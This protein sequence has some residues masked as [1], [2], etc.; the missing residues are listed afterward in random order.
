LTTD[1]SSSGLPAE[2]ARF[3]RFNVDLASGKLQRSGLNVAIQS[4]PFQVLRLLLIANG[5]VVS[6][7]QMRAA[8]WPEDTFVDFEHSLNT[9]VRKLRQ[10][11]EDSAETPKFVETLPKIG[12]RFLAS[13]E[14]AT[15]ELINN[16]AE[17]FVTT[18]AGEE[19]AGSDT[20]SPALLADRIDLAREPP[21][22]LNPALV[23]SAGALLLVAVSVLA[24]KWV[25]EES[26][27][28]SMLWRGKKHSE[29]FPVRTVRLFSGPGRIFPPNFS[30]D[31]KAIAF[32]WDGENPNRGDLYV[33]LVG[34]EK[35][36]RL[37]HTTSGF[38]CCAAWSPDGRQIAFGRC[39][40]QGGAVF[41]VPTLGGPERKLTDVACTYGVGGLPEWTPD[42][43]HLLLTDLC[44]PDRKGIVLFSIDTGEKK[45]LSGPP[46]GSV[47]DIFAR[48]SPDKKT[49]AFLRA[50][51]DAVNDLYTVPLQ[52]GTASQITSDRKTIFVFM[53]SND[54]R[55]IIFRSNRQ[56]LGRI[57]RASLS[58][59]PVEQETKYPEVGSLSADGRVVYTQTVE[60]WPTTIWRA[61]L[62]RAGGKVLSQKA[63]L[64]SANNN[65]S[66]QPSPDGTEVVFGSDPSGLGGEIWKSN[67]DGS[68]PIPLTSLGGHAGTPRWSPDGKW[69]AFD[70]RPGARSQIY[71]M[72][73]VGHN[74]HQI[75]TDNSNQVVPSW[76]RDGKSV[77]FASNRTGNYEVW[78][79][80]LETGRETQLTHHQGIAPVESYDG[81]TIYYSKFDGAGLWSVPVNGGEERLVSATIHHGYWGHFAVTEEGIYLLDADREEGPTIMFLDFKSRRL[82]PI[83]AMK[84]NPLPWTA[85]LAA[86]RDGRTLYFIQS[87][88]VS[89]IDMVENTP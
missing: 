72:D 46:V 15:D 1:W 39:N 25:P 69:I 5:Q 87:K 54:G 32:V 27:Y 67:S 79:R 10:A 7:E 45:C 37:T 53:W 60:N 56:G 57:W 61:D 34:G 68:D 24:V 59:A 86:S 2:R 26:G 52:G 64:S 3:D 63:V 74:L 55:H 82:S 73:S 38:L 23:L 28:F 31:G 33:Q 22:R 6:R 70:Y 50:P 9:A 21:T 43:K 17:R 42:G 66:P 78:C 71:V 16:Q 76:S 84:E 77:Y 48:L 44:G 30:P 19:A 8:L 35:P 75:T 14:W 36:L 41:A 49:V 20:D 40:D 89:S 29:S 18:A 80:D 85:S 12:Y 88:Q 47:G 65:D 62:L 83:L 51:T 13:V 58:G 11:L 81:K 4:Q